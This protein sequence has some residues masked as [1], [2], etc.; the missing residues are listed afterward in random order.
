MILF[1]MAMGALFAVVYAV[2]LGRVGNLRPRTLALLVAAGGF[3]GFYLVPFLKYPANPPA[4]GHE[5]TIKARS[6]LYLIMVVCSIAFLG[7]G[8]VAGPAAQAAVR[9]LERHAD[10]AWRRSSSRSAS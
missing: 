5:D 4:I 1:G 3:L 8:G 10:R 6:G 2:C 7:A 9:Q